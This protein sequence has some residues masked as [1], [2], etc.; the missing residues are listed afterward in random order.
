MTRQ[1]W[2]APGRYPPGLRSLTIDTTAAL[3]QFPLD[4]GPV[5]TEINRLNNQILVHYH[6]QEWSQV[7][8][9]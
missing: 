7:T 1:P 2:R 9:Q 5:E 6:E 4:M 3:F 8:Q